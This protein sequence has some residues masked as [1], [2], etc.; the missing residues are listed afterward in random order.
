LVAGTGDVA[1]FGLAAVVEDGVE[2][3]APG[4][5]AGGADAV[6]GAGLVEDGEPLEGVDPVVGED[7][8]GGA[9]GV[10]GGVTAC[11]LNSRP[12]VGGDGDGDRPHTA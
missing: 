6:G 9:V 2:A 7:P 3:D 10:P 1:G 5:A 4:F 12:T 11:S 8:A